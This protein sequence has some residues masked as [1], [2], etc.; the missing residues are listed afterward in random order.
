MPCKPFVT[1]R[2]FYTLVLRK[3]ASSSR[4]FIKKGEEKGM[5]A[6][7]V[8]PHQGNGSERTPAYI[9]LKQGAVLTLGPLDQASRD[10]PFLTG[11]VNTPT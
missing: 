1:Y 9:D 8:V 10:F 6:V 7:T 2:Y 3:S 4:R 11:K 5:E